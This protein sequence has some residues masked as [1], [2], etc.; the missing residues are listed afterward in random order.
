MN[1]ARHFVAL[2]LVIGC[3]RS[4]SAAAPPPNV[5]WWNFDG[6][7]GAQL[8]PNVGPAGN[9]NANRVPGADGNGFALDFN[10]TSQH[11]ETLTPIDYGGANVITV[12][13]RMKARDLTKNA[14]IFESSPT[15]TNASTFR[16]QVDA[17]RLVVLLRDGSPESGGTWLAAA[18]DVGSGK[19]N[20][21]TDV[22]IVLDN[23]S[24]AGAIK[25]YIDGLL[26]TNVYSVNTRRV[27]TTFANNVGY[28][29][30]RNAG[31]SQFFNGQIDDFGIYSG[32][33]SYQDIYAESLGP[34]LIPASRRTVWN[35]GIPG[36]IPNRTRIYTTLSPSGGDDTA[37]IQNALNNCPFDEVVKLAAGEFNVARTISIGSHRVLRGSGSSGSS[38]TKIR[39]TGGTE[40]GGAQVFSIGSASYPN[41]YGD[42]T[43]AVSGYKKGSTAITVADASRYQAGEY[44]YLVQRDTGNP[45]WLER[46]NSTWDKITPNTPGNPWN[47]FASL[48]QIGRITSVSG[49]VLN[50]ESRV[51]YDFSAACDPYVT[52]VK[53]SGTPTEYAGIEDLYIYR[54]QRSLSQ[55]GWSIGFYEAAFSWAK[56]CE[57]YKGEGRM[58]SM[59]RAYRCIVQSC[60]VH[61]SW[62]YASGA[63]SYAASIGLYSADNLWENNIFW[64][65]NGGITLE[66]CVGNVFAYNYI[67]STWLDQGDQMAQMSSGGSHFAWPTANLFEGNYATKF[68]F[69]NFH[70][71]SFN[72]TFFRNCLTGDNTNWPQEHAG[73]PEDEN[74]RATFDFA[75]FHNDKMNVVGNVLA[76]GQNVAAFD[77]MADGLQQ[78][79]LYI[80]RYHAA[81]IRDTV[82]HHGNYDGFNKSVV[83]HPANP[84][85]ELP[86]SLYLTGKPSWWDSQG[87]RP[88]PAIGP[89]LSPRV[90]D[91]P[92]KVK[93]DAIYSGTV[94][95]RP[96]PP[97]NLRIL[98]TP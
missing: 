4:A 92:A 37:A 77:G 10:G 81:H 98:L 80:Y 18:P 6:G 16:I 5:L 24:S 76:E 59:V 58:I 22:A 60:F 35:P 56:N 73:L 48:G 88:W 25:F 49:N 66:G 46:G 26:W 51:H 44:I 9:S 38:Q 94:A 33:V 84:D 96:S 75:Y 64:Y 2:A 32:E 47:D 28:F 45:D 89:D 23:R 36:G 29:G 52:R 67:N 15:I 61:H 62:N 30:A 1:I 11:A 42:W 72:Q 41:E 57:V 43:R 14:V 65:F 7:E 68:A 78:K 31:E 79:A 86:K 87:P 8:L 50:L 70:G 21:W 27:A 17:G 71:N 63:L 82:Y 13:F 12:R 97:S 39:F 40:F 85:H 95:N 34:G 3:L 83:W 69:D 90:S 54:T 93:F 74:D 55:G 91:I 19:L 20:V 53:A